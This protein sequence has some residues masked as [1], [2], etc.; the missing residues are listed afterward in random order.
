M[1]HYEHPLVNM[2][3]LMNRV[4]NLE[5]VVARLTE[6]LN[7]VEANVAHV[8]PPEPCLDPMNNAVIDAAIAALGKSITEILSRKHSPDDE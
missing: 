6:K 5:A 2:A 4:A 7:R 8:K 3:G 1:R